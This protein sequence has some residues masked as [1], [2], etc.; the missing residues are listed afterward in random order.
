MTRLTN[1]ALATKM[2]EVGKEEGIVRGGK[3][4]GNGEEDGNGKQQQG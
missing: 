1:S 4:N 2:R 3:C